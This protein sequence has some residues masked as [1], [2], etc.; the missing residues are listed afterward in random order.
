M[1]IFDQKDGKKMGNIRIKIGSN[2]E[3]RLKWPRQ[4]HFTFFVYLNEVIFVTWDSVM[5]IFRDK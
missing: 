4:V 5:S 3:L 2:F 1:L